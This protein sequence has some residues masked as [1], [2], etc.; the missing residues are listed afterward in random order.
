TPLPPAGSNS[1]A[2]GRHVQRRDHLRHASLQVRRRCRKGAGD[3]PPPPRMPTR[4]TPILVGSCHGAP[5]WVDTFYRP[6]N[7]RH[8]HKVPTIAGLLAPGD[9][10][11]MLK[12]CQPA[13]RLTNQF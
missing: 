6:P 2:T 3:G 13:N 8:L 7:V 1:P 5:F 12:K 10:C 9:P 11:D 4:K